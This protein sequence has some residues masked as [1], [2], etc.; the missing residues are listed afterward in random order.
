[1]SDDRSRDIDRDLLV[2]HLSGPIRVLLPTVVLVVTYPVILH[3]AGV[4][5]LGVWSLL[6]I[7]MAYT[8]LLDVGFTSVLTKEMAT[9]A[10]ELN[11]ERLAV[12]RKAASEC[13]LLGGAILTVLCLL[14]ASRFDALGVPTR[15][16]KPVL[17]GSV[18]LVLATVCQLLLRLELSVYKA[19]HRTYVEQWVLALSAVIMYLIG[20]AG[21]LVG[22]PIEGLAFGALLANA[23]LY[24]WA[25]LAVRRNFAQLF[26]AMGRAS[27]PV[28][29]SDVRDLAHAGKHFFSLAVV[30]VAREPVFRIL[31]GWT[32]GASAVGVYDIANRVPMLIRE[33]GASGS[34]ALFPGLARSSA[35][36]RSNELETRRLLRTAMFYLLAIGATGLAF[37]AVNRELIVALWLGKD[38]PVGLSSAALM[39]SG[40]WALTL[41]NV[42]FFWFLQARGFEKPLANSVWF[43]TAALLIVVGIMRPHL[44]SLTQLLWI[45]ILTGVTTQAYIYVVA[46]RAGGLTRAVFF[47]KTTSLYLFSWLL[48]S[49]VGVCLN[50][51]QSSTVTRLLYAALWGAVYALVCGPS[52]WKL[53]PGRW[54]LSAHAADA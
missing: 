39:M 21:A 14:V 32:L 35:L 54:G 20:L 42:P 2:S 30:F 37:F 6:S 50:G 41:F 22:R 28:R 1:M 12:W 40:W 51:R 44:A 29:L 25:R 17:L 46:E 5:V 3:R 49:V 16:Q 9:G 19:H 18:C 8:S 52:L 15:F 11:V 38:S 26:D 53:R 24:S 47:D 7:V 13:Y 43:H 34:Q 36:P 48:V 27:R 31:V 33:L 10:R 4:E 45:W 23:A